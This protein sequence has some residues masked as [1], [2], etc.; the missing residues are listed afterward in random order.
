M[1]RPKG[2]MTEA[3][4]SVGAG[5][6]NCQSKLAKRLRVPPKAAALKIGFPTLQSGEELRSEKPISEWSNSCAEWLPTEGIS[7]GEPA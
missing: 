7:S 4:V 2:K 6:M 3:G 1:E 5:A